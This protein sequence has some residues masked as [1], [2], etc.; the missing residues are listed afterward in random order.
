MCGGL[1]IAADAALA[2]DSMRNR[3]TL[4]DVC[5]PWKDKTRFIQINGSE[6]E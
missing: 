4:P 2:E 5:A 6:K 1:R 3:A